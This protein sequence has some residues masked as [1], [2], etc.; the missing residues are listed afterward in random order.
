[1]TPAIEL[2]LRV[3]QELAPKDPDALAIQYTRYNDLTDEERDTVEQLGRK[4]H[5]II[6]ERLRNVAGRRAEP[7]AGGSSRAG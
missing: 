6:R 3:L 2:R 5:V 7:Q 1:M 4:G